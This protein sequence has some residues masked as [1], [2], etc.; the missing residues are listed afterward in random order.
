MEGNLS[1]CEGGYKP[2]PGQMK[3]ELTDSSGSQARENLFVRT[4]LQI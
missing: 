1:E 2:L 4:P 3:H